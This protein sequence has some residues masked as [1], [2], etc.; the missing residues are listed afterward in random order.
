MVNG[1]TVSLALV[2]SSFH[3]C[4]HIT[5]LPCCKENA[6]FFRAL[7]VAEWVSVPEASSFLFF[8]HLMP[9]LLQSTLLVGASLTI[10]DYEPLMTQ[11]ASAPASKS[12][13]PKMDRILISLTSATDGL[14]GLV[15]E[16]GV[17]SQSQG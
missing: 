3:N 8:V 2:C 11:Y 16:F 15:A 5:E 13:L 10:L 17:S 6:L 1:H 4:I 9:Q 14:S 7:I 12:K